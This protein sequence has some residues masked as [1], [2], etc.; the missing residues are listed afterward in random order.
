MT[1]RIFL[2]AL[3]AASLPSVKRVFTAP[4]DALNTADLP[5]LWPELPGVGDAAI[6]FGGDYWPTYRVRLVLAIEPVAQSTRAQVF[7]RTVDLL[8]EM[9]ATYEGVDAALSRLS[10]SAQVAVTEVAGTAYWAVACD[11]EGSG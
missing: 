6:T 8:D 9:L 10:L 7:A 1:L 4:P 2:D 11:V 3:L 5:A